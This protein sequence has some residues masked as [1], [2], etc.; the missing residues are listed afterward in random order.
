MLNLEQI[1]K[2]AKHK[3][4]ASIYFVC[5]IAY[6]PEKGRFCNISGYIWTKTYNLH[7]NPSRPQ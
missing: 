7:V 6:P 5:S 4:P 3:I 1:V 2:F